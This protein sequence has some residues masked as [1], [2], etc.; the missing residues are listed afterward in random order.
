[1]TYITKNKI[2]RDIAMNRLT[3][4]LI[5][6]GLTYLDCIDI[7]EYEE[8]C[9]S[10]YWR[11]D[12]ITKKEKI[13]VGSNIVSLPMPQIQI[14]LRHEVLHRTTFNSFA[15]RFQNSQLANIVFDTC[16]NR[17]L[18]ISFPD[19]MIELAGY[20]YSI[21]TYSTLLCLPNPNAS[22]DL[23]SNEFKDLWI[24]IWRTNEF[25]NYNNF[26]STSLYYKLETEFEKI[27][28]FI[29]NPG[30]GENILSCGGGCGQ[31]HKDK[32][33]NLSMNES[34]VKRSNEDAFTKLANS[35][36]KGLNTIY[37]EDI[38][39]HSIIPI[40]VGII[41]IKKFLNRIKAAKIASKVVSDLNSEDKYIYK[42]RPYPLFPSNK[43][44]VYLITGISQILNM[45]HNKISDINYSKLA[46]GIYIDMS[47]SMEKYFPIL[48]I[49][50]G[51]LKSIPIQI[52]GFTN[53]LYDINIDD[54]MNGT[55]QGGGGTDFN[56]IFEDLLTNNKLHSGL[57]ITDGKADIT[58]LNIIRFKSS[59]KKLYQIL[60]SDKSKDPLSSLVDA[61]Y[62]FKYLQ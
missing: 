27:K 53:Y 36:F 51:H 52:K 4:A 45:Y 5:S 55:I 2:T 38:F 44:L 32:N 15:E 49:F 26:T 60:F 10:A 62:L 56:P 18:Y 48:P 40:D 54:I 14:V 3:K 42:F 6:M 11:Y 24:F 9:E 12:S 43:G 47:G 61:E 22:I 28:N 50:I 19:E 34:E 1:M 30:S 17:M 57:I 23:I 29:P 39:E 58:P 7:I 46:L 33:K 13:V 41:G 21:D 31:K 20:I 25:G 16:I 37:G 35:S 59:E 8:D